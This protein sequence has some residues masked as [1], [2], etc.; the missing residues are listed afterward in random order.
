[1]KEKKQNIFVVGAN[2][3]KYRALQRLGQDDLG[4]LI[5]VS[6]QT[7]NTWEAKE[8]VKLDMDTVNL[9]AKHLKVKSNDL[10]IDKTFHVEHNGDSNDKSGKIPFFDAVAMGG[11]QRG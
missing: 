9:I 7:V 2:I 3:K 1:M 10:I 8:A 5:G 6:R 11:I 4:D